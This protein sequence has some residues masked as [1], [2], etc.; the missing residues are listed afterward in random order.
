MMTSVRW[1][2]FEITV[3]VEGERLG[4]KLDIGNVGVGR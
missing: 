1:L 4:G 2:V 3:L